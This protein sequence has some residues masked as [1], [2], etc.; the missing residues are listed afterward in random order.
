MKFSHRFDHD[1]RVI[2]SFCEH[3]GTRVAS[4]WHVGDLRQAERYHACAAEG[5]PAG[6]QP[7]VTP[8]KAPDSAAA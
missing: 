5:R 7:S 4:S 1:S 3:C 2:H 8:A 6:K